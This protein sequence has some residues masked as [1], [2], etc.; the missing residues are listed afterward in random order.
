M[1]LSKSKKNTAPSFFSWGFHILE[2]WLS[3]KQ[4][5]K[6]LNKYFEDNLIQ[7]VAIYGLGVLGKRLYDELRDTQLQISYGIDQNAEKIQIYGLEVK[8][9]QVELADV[10][11]IVVTP[12]AFYE[13]EQKLRRKMGSEINIVSIEDVVEYCAACDE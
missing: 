3:I 13:I 9:L 10:D 11:I 4:K 5:G 2:Q 7:T 12:M 1:R 8:T 6:S